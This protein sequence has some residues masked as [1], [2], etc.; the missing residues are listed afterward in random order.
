ML[1]AMG[2]TLWGAIAI[3]LAAAVAVLGYRASL[4]YRPEF[5]AAS[6]RV[7]SLPG[8]QPS[9]TPTGTEAANA[10]PRSPPG[11]AVRRHGQAVNQQGASANPGVT[12]LQTEPDSTPAALSDESTLIGHYLPPA[13]PN[14]RKNCKDSAVW[15]D[16]A[17]VAARKA[18]EA[19]KE[20][21][22]QFKLQ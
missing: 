15:A 16:R 21:L 7:G 20:N 19:P 12:T 18:G 10:A 6:T 22:Y 2:A 1:N 14:P 4:G 11:A 3:T 17:I 9:V 5:Q 8:A 13:G